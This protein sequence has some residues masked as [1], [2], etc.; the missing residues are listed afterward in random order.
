MHVSR[1]ASGMHVGSCD[2]DEWHEQRSAAA[3]VLC[4]FYLFY[5]FIYLFLLTTFNNFFFHLFSSVRSCKFIFFFSLCHFIEMRQAV[6]FEWSFRGPQLT[7][8]KALKSRR[9][10]LSAR[11]AAPCLKSTTLLTPQSWSHSFLFLFVFLL[12][13]FTRIKNFFLSFFSRS[14]SK[15][16]FFFLLFNN[17]QIFSHSTNRL[18]SE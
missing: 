12:E 4:Y 13:A 11:S 10:R 8:L 14:D 16:S 17:T 7:W 3:S 15:F 1:I 18:P 5:I 9:R 6:I 2:G